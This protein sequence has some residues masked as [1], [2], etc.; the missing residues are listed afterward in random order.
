MVFGPTICRGGDTPDLDMRFQTALTR[1]CGRMVEFRSVSLEIRGRKERRRNKEKSAV[2]HKPTYM[3]VSEYF[4]CRSAPRCR[5]YYC[6]DAG[7]VLH[8][9]SAP[10]SWPYP[11]YFDYCC[12]KERCG[13]QNTPKMRF[14][15]DSAP[16]PAGELTTPSRSPSPALCT[17][18]SAPRFSRLRYSPLGA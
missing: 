15:P 11:P 3:Y 10:K 2:K 1:P 18:P 9:G 16:D 8:W 6:I 7:A 14:R 5:L 4:P 13:L 12:K 17:T